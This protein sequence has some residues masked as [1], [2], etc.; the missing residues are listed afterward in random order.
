MNFALKRVAFPAFLYGFQS[1]FGE[2]NKM[3]WRTICDIL[4]AVALCLA[5]FT[6]NLLWNIFCENI[7]KTQNVLVLTHTYLHLSL[8]SKLL[9]QGEACFIKQVF[10]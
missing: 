10:L 3:N 7:T 4:Q 9:P 2:N 5:N 1:G 8:C 6:V